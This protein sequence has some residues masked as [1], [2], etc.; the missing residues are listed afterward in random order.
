MLPPRMPFPEAYIAP[1]QSS[2]DRFVHAGRVIRGYPNWAYLERLRALWPGTLMVKGADGKTAYQRARG[3]NGPAK[4]VC[5]GEICRY[6][7]RANEG[8]IGGSKWHWSTAFEGGGS[9]LR[10]PGTVNPALSSATC[11]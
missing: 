2:A 6:K 3:A 8:G 10:G 5:C 4:L 9:A 1:G 11:A 7:C